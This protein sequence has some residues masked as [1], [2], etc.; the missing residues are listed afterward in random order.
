[1][2]VEEKWDQFRECVDAY[3]L[4]FHYVGGHVGGGWVGYPM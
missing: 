2:V 4:Q 3:V 1:M